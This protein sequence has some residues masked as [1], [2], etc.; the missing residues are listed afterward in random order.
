MTG[1]KLG[2]YDVLEKLGEGGMGMV[3]KA[4]DASLGRLAALKILPAKIAAM[5]EARKRFVQEAQAASAL[6][7]SNIVTIYEIAHESGQDYIAMELVE[8]APLTQLIGRKGLA[9]REAVGLAIQVAA[10]LEA[11]HAAGIVHRDLKPGNVMVTVDGV[12]KV[13]DFGLAKLVNNP[14]SGADDITQTILAAEAPLTTEGSIVGTVCYMSPE[15][16]EG[17]KV[18]PRSD[19]FSFGALL[20]E[21]LT[22]QRAF[23]GDSAVS[24]MAAILTR[25]PDPVSGVAPAVPRELSKIVARC[26]R[27]QPAKRWQSMADIKLALEDFAQEYEAGTLGSGERSA[28]GVPAVLRERGKGWDWVAMAGVL[29]LVVGAGLIWKLAKSGVGVPPPARWRIQRVTSDT[30]A[31]LSAAMSPDGKLVAYSSDRA[32]E[33]SFDIWVQQVAGGDPVRLTKD[34]GNCYE[35]TFSSDGGQLVFR[36]DSAGGGGGVYT[37][38]TLGGVPRR[39]A[40]GQDPQFSPDGSRIAYLPNGEYST[41]ATESAILIIPAQGGA[42]KEVK[43]KGR[44]YGHPLWSAD[45]K[46][47]L[48]MANGNSPPLGFDWQYVSEDGRTQRLLG[49]WQHVIEISPNGAVPW[50]R[51]G[52]D[53]LFN[54]WRADGANVYRMPLDERTH[55]VTGPPEAVTVG[56][57][58]NFKPSASADGTRIA[59]GNGTTVAS[60]LWS[61]NFEEGSGKIAGRAVK[62]TEG[63]ERRAA[64]QP[65]RDGN[66]VVYVAQF[67]TT[68]EVR[69]RD[70]TTGKEI[71]LAAGTPGTTAAISPDGKQ[72]AYSLPAQ[73]TSPIFLVASNGGAPKKVC[74]SCGRPIEWVS[75]TA[76]LLYDR[77][78]ENKRAFWALDT[79]TGQ[80]RMLANVSDAGLFTPRVSPGGKW[81]VFTEQG[82]GSNRKIYIAPFGAG[83]AEIP[84]KD[85]SVVVEG[86]TLDRQP[87]WSPSGSMIVFLSD[88][89]GSRCVWGR[90]IDTATGKPTGDVFGVRHFHEVRENLSD[91][92]DPWNVGL[93]VAGGK[94]FFAAFEIAGNVWMMEKLEP[95]SEPAQ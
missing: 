95:K 72:V 66:S 64:L 31:S 59:F 47:F 83:K 77:D 8:G 52:K 46:G 78:T 70:L 20:Y 30:G 5:E 73:G 80:K 18:D 36:C 81:V 14:P 65:S 48:V 60:N 89:D 12:A 38:A 90:R 15:Q 53:V 2:H 16:A 57:G 87:Y 84:Q 71:R 88:R 11:A 21:M 50:S 55:E 86:A 25:D 3:F 34:L 27:K 32:G 74:D 54:S 9:V 17:K 79:A 22:G 39:V 6:N 49:A 67:A 68:T 92:G 7:H 44:I 75:G 51:S 43:V 24:T 61:V 33:G 62:L 37:V 29:G 4:R 26:L 23:H 10:A 82:E 19:I 58:F 69:L 85:W 28:V 13:L 35:A 41:T 1:S 94:L 56:A 63:L 42:A 91:M 93:S 45:G 76:M 40:D